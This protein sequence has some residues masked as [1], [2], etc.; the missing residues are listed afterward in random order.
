MKIIKDRFGFTLLELAIVMAAASLVAGAVV[1]SFLRTAMINGAKKTALDIIQIEEAGRSYYVKNKSWPSD[2][3][4]L[5]NDGFLD[6]N[7]DRKNAFGRPYSVERSGKYLNVKTSVRSEVA[8]VVKGLVPM[9]SINVEMITSTVPVPGV[10]A[11][12]I[13]IGTIVPWPGNDYPH[14]WLVCDGRQVSRS[15]HDALFAVLGALYGS[16]DG[17]STFNLPDLRGRVIVGLDNMG[18]SIA[19][20]ITSDWARKTGGT[21]G[22]EYHRLTLAEIP[23]HTHGYNETPWQ[24]SR[25]DG[26]SSPVM[27]GQVGSVTTPAG[28]DRP[29]NNIQPSMAMNWLIKG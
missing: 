27:T 16:G 8:E 14:G 12:N 13:P 7:W 3:D 15:E 10:E 6:P 21:F 29:H 1:P 19:N 24:G 28:G 23:S 5:V 20:I 11:D 25:Y 22:E 4:V 18:G 9:T 26:H 2:L 17:Y